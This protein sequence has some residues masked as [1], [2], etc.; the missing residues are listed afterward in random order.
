MNSNFLIKKNQVDNDFVQVHLI[1]STTTTS[2]LNNNLSTS[3]STVTTTT[4]QR[5]NN[6]QQQQQLSITTNLDMSPPLLTS[7]KKESGN[8]KDY[9]QT[10]IASSSPSLYPQTAQDPQRVLRQIMNLY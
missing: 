1:D 8:T 2:T 10:E 6:Q 5:N 9:Y 7:T 4:I 3:S